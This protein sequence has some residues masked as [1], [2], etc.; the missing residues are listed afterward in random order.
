[1]VIAEVLAAL[2]NDEG[3]KFEVVMPLVQP[4]VEFYGEILQVALRGGSA[5]IAQLGSST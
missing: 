5:G 2:P 4:L 3:G 1:M